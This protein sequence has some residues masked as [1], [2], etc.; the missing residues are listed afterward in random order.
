MKRS[1]GILYFFVVLLWLSLCC[2]S[3]HVL[4]ACYRECDSRLVTEDDEVDVSCNED[5][6]VKQ[7]RIGCQ[8]WA[9][10]IKTS[11]QNACNSTDVTKGKVLYRFMGCN[12]AV[13]AY[14]E[15]IKV[16]FGIPPAPYLV[17][18][19]KTNESVVIEWNPASLENVSY[20]VQWKYESLPGD[21]EYYNP[22]NILK[23]NKVLI[24]GLHPYTKYKF[25]VAWI[26]LPQ[27]A[28]ILSHESVEISTLPYGVPTTAPTITSL[29]ALG[30]RRI[31]V[32]WEPP[33]FSNGPILSYVLYLQEM[34]D[35]Y[36]P[37]K[38]VSESVGELYYMFNN[39]VPDTTYQVSITTRNSMGEGPPD[40][41]NVT[42]PSI[43]SPTVLS[44]TPYL[45]L[46]SQQKVLLQGLDF[47]ESSELL[48]LSK[49]KFNH[50]VGVGL[51]VKKKIIFVSDTSGSVHS[52][53]LHQK[54]KVNTIIHN[55][56]F[57]PGLLSVDWLN[58]HL[59]M[60]EKNQISRCN[61]K[62]TMCQVVVSGFKNKPSTFHVDPYNGFLFWAWEEDSET[63]LYSLDLGRISSDSVPA[64][65]GHV[66]MKGT[67]LT[68][69]AVDH[70]NFQLLVPVPEKNTVF[71]VTMDGA[72]QLDVRSNSQQPDFTQVKS[73]VTY[74]RFFY[75]IKQDKVFKEEYHSSE[76]KYFH[77]TFKL[78]KTVKEFLGVKILHSDYQ[79]LPVPVNPVEKVQVVFHTK[80]AKIAWSKPRRPGG[81]GSGAWQEWCYEVHLE[82][83]KAGL[84]IYRKE[85][86]ETFC[87]IQNLLPNTHYSVKVRA[88]NRGGKG[89]WS[90]LFDGKTLREGND[91]DDI[92]ILWSGREGLAKTNIIGDN[93]KPLINKR[94]LGDNFIT[95]ISWYNGLVFLNTNNS[96]VFMYNV[97]ETESLIHLQNV[98]NAASIT[99][100]WLAPKLYWSSPHQQ[101]IS[102]SN[103]DGSYPEHLHLYTLAQELAIDSVRG[104]LYWTTTHT[105]EYSRLN[106]FEHHVYFETEPFS[107]KVIGLSMDYDRDKV[108]WVI[109][110]FEGSILYE[111][112]LVSEEMKEH[113]IVKK[114]GVISDLNMR[115]P[116]H[117]LSDRFFWLGE[118]EGALI[119]DL[120]GHNLAKL[121]IQGLKTIWTLAVI[122]GSK[123]S[124]PGVKHPQKVNVS[125]EQIN[126][127]DI[128]ISGNWDDFKIFWPAT[129]HVNFGQVFY[130]LI[131]NSGQETIAVD[132][133]N[134]FFKPTKQFVPYT[135]LSIAVRA[136]TYWASSKQTVVF[137]N[138]P[139]S[140][141]S[142]P[143]NPRVYIS[144]HS[145]PL[146]SENE[147][148]IEAEFRWS[149]PARKN[150]AIEEYNISCWFMQDGFSLA[151]CNRVF[152][153]STQHYYRLTGLLPDTLYFFQ[154]SARTS[155]GEGPPCTAVLG[156]TSKENPVPH[157]LL[158]EEDAMKISDIDRKEERILSNKVSQPVDAVYLGQEH[159]IYWLEENG[160][161]M[162]SSM[163]GTDTRLIH[164][165]PPGGTSM[166]LDWVGRFLFWSESSLNGQQTTIWTMD[167]SRYSDPYPLVTKSAV[168]GGMEVDPLSST[169]IYTL[170]HDNHMA[171]LMACDINGKNVRP[172]FM[173]HT[174]SH[175][176][177]KRNSL[178][179][180]EEKSQ[181]CNCFHQPQV[182]KAITIDWSQKDQPVLLWIDGQHGNIW[183][184]D[185]MGCL[186]QLLINASSNPHILGLPPTSIT[187]DKERIYWSNT[188][189]GR[190][191]SISKNHDLP[192]WTASALTASESHHYRTHKSLLNSNEI[193]YEDVEGVRGIRAI[194]EH[195]QPYPD[196]KCLVPPSYSRKAQLQHLTSS[197]VTLY[198][199]PED[200]PL[201]CHKVSLASVLYTVYYGKS[202][203][204]KCKEDL[205]TCQS[206]ETYNNTVMIKN[207]SPFTNYTVRVANSNYYSLSPSAAGPAVSFQ[208]KEGVPSQ[209]LNVRGETITP[210]RIDVS[211]SPPVI[212][213]GDPITY[214]VRLKA[215]RTDHSLVFAKKHSSFGDRLMMSLFPLN[216]DT[217][218]F[219]VVRA[220]SSGGDSDSEEVEVSTFRLPSNLSLV[221]ATSN[222]LL[223]QWPSPYRRE[224][225]QHKLEY[226]KR[227]DESGRW[228]SLDVQTTDVSTYYDFKLVSL[229]PKTKYLLHLILLYRNTKN[230]TFLWPEA[231]FE[232][233]TLG[234]QPL[235]PDPPY[236]RDV[237]RGVS[238]VVWGEVSDNGG[239]YLLYELQVRTWFKVDDNETSWRTVYNNSNNMWI[240]EGLPA[241]VNYIFRVRAINNYGSSNFSTESKSFFLPE[242]SAL[243]TQEGEEIAIILASSLSAVFLIILFLCAA[244]ILVRKR[245]ENDK[246][247]LQETGRRFQDTDLELAT[248]RELPHHSNFVHQTNALYALEDIPT[249]EELAILPQIRREQ[250]VLTKFLG[251]G[252]FGEVFEGVAHD[253]E[254]EGSA[255]TKVAIKTLRKGATDQEKGEFL[256]EAKLMSNFKHEHIL[257]L[258]GICLDNNPNFII[259][260]LMEGGDLLSYLRSNRNA[261][262]FGRNPLTMTDLLGI[263]ID[264]ARGCVYLEEMHFVHRD[265]AAR[266]CL[267]SSHDPL[268]RHVKIGDFGLAR[269][270]YKNDY[271]RKE[272]EGLLPVRWMA[273]ESLMD[274]VFTNQSDVWAFGVLLWEVLTLGQQPYPART[275]L[276]VL[277]YVRN[278]G[279]LDRP[280]N[281]HE[282]LHQLM[283]W[284]WSY[285]PLG[286]P[287]FGEC[288]EVLIDLQNKGDETTTAVNTVHNHHYMAQNFS[289]AF[290]N[291]AYCQD[292]RHPEIQGNPCPPHEHAESHHFGSASSVVKHP[293]LDIGYT[294]GEVQEADS[295]SAHE[296]V[297]E[298]QPCSSGPTADGRKAKYLDLLA[299]NVSLTDH[300]G[301]EIP[302]RANLTVS[303]PLNYA[304]LEAK[305]SPLTVNDKKNKAK[306]QQNSS[307]HNSS[308]PPLYAQL[309][310]RS[311]R[312]KESLVDKSSVNVDSEPIQDIIKK[313]KLNPMKRN[314]LVP[315]PCISVVNCD[316]HQSPSS[317]TEL[318]AD[319]E[320]TVMVEA[321]NPAFV[322]Q[323]CIPDKKLGVHNSTDCLSSSLAT[324][325]QWSLSTTSTAALQSSSNS[326]PESK[327]NSG[328]SSLSAVSGVEL[329]FIPKSS[330]C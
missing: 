220:C 290:E 119:S 316:P 157:L 112:P 27:Y 90:D 235:E 223:V 282:D 35:G 222:S 118:N 86:S 270:I 13:T 276:E 315:S 280:D 274:G 278:R 143:E 48:Y 156:N 79:P 154:V 1:L 266:N 246:K 172:F 53:L 138:T 177:Q 300:D 100:D 96:W 330:W 159:A 263:C 317:P 239:D 72:D 216:P 272:G 163:N 214:E 297:I 227:D 257:Q 210:I 55:S 26:I 127:T 193:V 185:M 189:M 295:F 9:V 134:N 318:L 124:I 97:S 226:V 142:A 195:L 108:Y 103:I 304:D 123:K 175:S 181:K 225:I 130:N 217:T 194:G 65:S 271:Y 165:L 229:L 324:T 58:D 141:P 310:P 95:D 6:K 46:W 221:S 131:I 319:A 153:P 152:V 186:C 238:Q 44:A 45:V 171:Q 37:I 52:I 107:G 203:G 267:V 285:D 114:V 41:K 158:A 182:G 269:D 247:M 140:A 74:N 230:I 320:E 16:K 303:K 209:P 120:N 205:R 151:V 169:L 253:L 25:R 113:N 101:M 302:I 93:M 164:N 234:D 264:V 265:L 237:G 208:T 34:P 82:D 63:R 260:E 323:L 289:G 268:N 104:Q 167:F 273:P 133:Q 249:D 306:T 245:R 99:I 329:D 78:D 11:C 212:P 308:P 178:Q 7:C 311:R 275:N 20:L 173:Q 51:H 105:I 293:Y 5:C 248:L 160:A 213:N 76:D 176:L 233:E 199:P 80:M 145:S 28:P 77:I 277:H 322:N 12:L 250:I 122:N 279:R 197:F 33:P 251:S 125:P 298:T 301:Y 259:M 321:C 219:I 3:V 17:A 109:R 206:I 241:K 21:W 115:G 243:A 83:Q 31:S 144:H 149:P 135:Q 170:L 291:L 174:D 71:T 179:D 137:L 191:Y 180:T 19:S 73:L 146:K 88:Y 106:G 23:T 68:T 305:R 126:A 136:Y 56:T 94:S 139:M 309:F 232:F 47:I 196:R 307:L 117:Y 283:L 224:I 39:L 166:V 201:S 261:H 184:S 59:Y 69:F 42:T 30:P 228:N 256:K 40:V 312:K 36:D 66:I 254:G 150:G 168:I 2:F 61:L 85:I 326:T 231:G 92:F 129:M 89:P 188:S 255:P 14:I 91:Q 43:P 10:A 204:N 187:A 60:E 50:I 190:V 299:D 29:A 155:V 161:L 84:T 286:R 62:G 287:N 116:L 240:I 148:S 64:D 252:A 215:K 18:F 128:G 314:G 198:L 200:L 236:V 32:S 218:Y 258:L 110:S 111:A 24:E 38:D 162:S 294:N 244:V 15:S 81:F 8:R 98:T 54:D 102:R 328:L 4:D 325:D 207:L 211:W 284:C 192:G 281:C 87:T 292:E 288:L 67:S 327:R 22:D 202:D 183:S 132:T 262:L 75:W 296:S 57:Y 147:I 242:P 70:K 313:N 121:E 49:D